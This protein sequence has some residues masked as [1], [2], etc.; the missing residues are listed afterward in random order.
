MSTSSSEDTILYD[1]R[2]L[3]NDRTGNKQK[4]NHKLHTVLQKEE[5][6]QCED[7]LLLE[8]KGLTDKELR[9]RLIKFGE[10]PGPISRHTRPTYMQRLRCLL[11]ESK[12]KSHHQKLQME[13]QQT[14]LGY[15]PEL[16]HVLQNFKLPDCQADEQALCQQFDQPDQNKKWREGIIKSSFN[17]LLLDP[18]VTRN[19]PFRSHTMSQQECFQTFIH[20][21]FYVGKG[22]RSSPYSHLYEALEYYKE[23]KTSKKLCSKVQHILQVWNAQQGVISLHCF[24]NV[25]PVEAYTREACMVEAIGLKMLTNQKWGDF[26]GIVS[27]WQVKRKRE[28]GIHL[29]YRAM[30]IFLAEGERQLRPAYIRQ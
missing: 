1:W 4:E 5:S 6:G 25:I 26:Y 19:L 3:Q 8:T 28:L 21:I 18:R 27:N 23:L 10:S 7:S 9:L 30:Q 22:K 12:S 16:C 24:Q 15:S 17:Y 14:D 20:A 2:A 11:K 29:L 13:Q